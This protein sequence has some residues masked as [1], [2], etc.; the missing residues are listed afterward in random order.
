ML[1]SEEFEVDV[2]TFDGVV[3]RP[4]DCDV[5][6]DD[7]EEEVRIKVVEAEGVTK[8]VVEEGFGAAEKGFGTSESTTPTGPS[9]SISV[10]A[11]VN[12]SG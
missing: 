10:L 1:I 5:D 11:H 12:S 9:K 3:L 2:D 8:R 7:E 4:N 6:D